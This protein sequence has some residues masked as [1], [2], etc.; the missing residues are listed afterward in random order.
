M[1]GSTVTATPLSAKPSRERRHLVGRQQ[2]QLGHVADRDPSAALVLVGQFAHQVDVHGI[3][4]G[5]D[6]EMNVDV[7]VELARELE[8]APDLAGLVLV[9]ARRAADHLGAALEPLDQQ[10]VGARIAGQA[11]LRKHADLDVDRP[12][13]VGDQRLHAFEAAHA[14]AGIDLDLRAHAGGAVLDALLERALGARAHVLD[15]HARLE[16]RDALDRAQ[17]CAAPAARSGR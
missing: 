13:V 17:A 6:V 4:R 10:L 12:L 11:F 9:V 5:A 15:R 7:D 16:R 3:G 8:D 14:D 2:R 1:V